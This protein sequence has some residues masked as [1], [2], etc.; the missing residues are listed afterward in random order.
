MMREYL[1]QPLFE[2]LLGMSHHSRKMVESPSKCPASL[3][4]RRIS[5]FNLPRRLN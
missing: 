2:R 1:V 4:R 3:T 5:R